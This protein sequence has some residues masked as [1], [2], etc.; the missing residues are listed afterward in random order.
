MNQKEKTEFPPITRNQEKNY[1]I[2]WL[3][4]HLTTPSPRSPLAAEKEITEEKHPKRLGEP[5]FPS[6]GDSASPGGGAVSQ[7]FNSVC[8]GLAFNI[9]HLEFLK[10]NTGTK[11]TI[12]LHVSF[13]HPQPEVYFSLLEKIKTKK[14]SK[15]IEKY[16]LEI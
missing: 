12:I 3:P 16:C 5:D 13:T 14:K 4:T 8:S 11:V 6:Q 7:L 9:R 1:H 10:I 2:S 15:A